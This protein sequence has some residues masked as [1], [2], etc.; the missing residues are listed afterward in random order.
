MDPVRN[1]YSP[2]AGTP[3]PAFVGRNPLLQQANIALQR[4][5][6]Q[7]SAKSLILVGLRGVGKTV[8]LGRIRDEAQA[9][10]YKALMIEVPEDK[11]IG[12]MLLP[13]LRQILLSLDAMANVSAKVKR[14]LRV[15]KSFAS[16]FKVAYGGVELGID[17]EVGSADSGDLESDLGNLLEAVAEAAADRDTAVAICIDELQYLS[18]KDL[19]ALIMAIHRVAQKQ[20]PLVVF[21]AGLPQ[22]VGHAGRSKSY[23][24]RLF[25][26]PEI[27]PLSRADAQDALR[28]PARAEGVDFTPEALEEIYRVTE[29]YPYFLQQWAYD[30]WNT[31]QASPIDLTAVQ[32]AAPAALKGLDASFFRVRFDRLTP[33]EK[34]YMRTMALGGPNPQRSGE[35]AER[36]S[37]KVTTIAPLRSSLIAKGMIYSPAHGDNAFTVPLMDQYL[38]RV[39]PAPADEDTEDDRPASPAAEKA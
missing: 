39:M 31:A 6:I 33:R 22:I 30:V 32:V 19:S 20:L 23:A 10:G 34:A 16:V 3:P 12:E 14:G 18:E 13:P 9:A 1:P 21:G 28:D 4:I 15:L 25:D 27:G 24:E 8:I 26:F 5:Q 11:S 29:G 37:V 2:G 38:L 7:R 17:A 35:I 36:M